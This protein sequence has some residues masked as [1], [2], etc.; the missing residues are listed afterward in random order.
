VTTTHYRSCP[1]CEA[2]CGV[3]IEVD[4]DRV[5]SVRG[6]DA[7]PFSK[8]YICP[9]G[10]ALADLHHDP[11][12]LRSPMRRD[13]D[14]WQPIGWDEALDLVATKLREIRARYGADAVAVYQGN[15]SAHNL[16]L[17]TYGQLTLRTLGTKN[18]YSATSL[19]QLPHMLAAL[20]MFGNQLLMPV[21]D[22]DRTDLFICLGANPLASNGSI[23]TAPD[24]RGRLK[25]VR[26]RGGRVIV[27]DPRRTETADKADRHLFI[28]PGTDAVLL[29]AM[30]GVLF[31]EH[32]VRLGR[33]RA[34]GPELERGAFIPSR[35]LDELRVASAAWPVERAAQITGVAAADIRELARALATTERAVLYGR[36]GVCVQEFGG[37]AA[38]LCYAINALT[39]HLDEPGGL[40]FSTPAVDPVPLAKLIGLDGG[41]ARWKSRVSGKPEF[42]G[43]LPVSVLGE[44]ILTPGP[45]QVRALVTSAG[46]PVLS[47]PGGPDLE[48]ALG[49]LDFMVSIDPYINETTRLSHVILPPTSPLERSHYDAALNAFAVRN[50]A[51]YSP[52]LFER[53]AG[54]RHD[55]EIMAGLLARLRLAVA[56]RVAER[57]MSKLGPE[58]IVEL[59]LRTG[60]HGLRRGRDGLS[61]AKLRATP[62]GI[63]LGPLES[64]LPGRLCTSDK[65]LH[66]APKIYLD[67]L[68]RLARRFAQADAG[69]VMIGRRHLRSN[70]SWMHN[71]ERLVKGPP[72][73]T[74]MIHP[75]D[76]AKRGLVDGGQAR[77]ATARGAIELPVEVTDAM[78]PGVVSVPHGWGHGRRGVQ[79]RVAQRVPGVSVNDVIDPARIDELSGTSAL[80]GQP[81]EVTPA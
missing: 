57:L 31:D 30:I 75:D 27:L 39:G 59:A 56:S 54:E 60:P 43:E 50:V 44:E 78:M 15:P 79:L 49:T 66:L 68:A 42:G 23:M 63:D 74:L 14:R 61:L 19:D 51:K 11:D 58:A 36:V 80:T 47:A 29:L 1:L 76:A 45:G 21:P 25:A 38:W 40:M 28:R 32:L 10:T 6:D 17:L 48:R 77:V 72:R 64:R 69:L 18:M 22:V 16:G 3:A 5:V 73:C 67:D 62:H 52:A 33:L 8:G 71:S 70:N 4:G 7:D 37:L 46:N 53:P 34:Q 24:I 12:R 9:K 35:G 55:W 13:G 65:K 41:F 20:V 2:T 26:D 81:V